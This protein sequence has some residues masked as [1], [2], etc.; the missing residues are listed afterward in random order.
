M[1]GMAI[2]TFLVKSNN[3][4]ISEIGNRYKSKNII[5]LDLV[6]LG[7]RNQGCEEVIQL[8]VDG[9]A[10]IACARIMPIGASVVFIYH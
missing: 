1:V 10:L 5:C 4:C 7:T 6:P 9:S 3:T 8:F 2:Y